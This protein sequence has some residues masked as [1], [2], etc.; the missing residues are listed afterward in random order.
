LPDLRRPRRRDL[1]R[2]GH[3][4]ADVPASRDRRPSGARHLGPV[5]VRG[6][7]GVPRRRGARFPPDASGG[8]P[9]TDDDLTFALPGQWWR[10]PVQDT[11][12]AARS[13]RAFVTHTVGKADEHAQL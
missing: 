9:M 11:E 12:A 2:V 1:P 6:P 13:I 3:G 8:P 4:A 10:I 7:E 5:R